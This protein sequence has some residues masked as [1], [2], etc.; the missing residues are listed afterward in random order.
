MKLNFNIKNKPDLMSCNEGEYYSDGGASFEWLIDKLLNQEAF[1]LKKNKNVFI[2]NHNFECVEYK[3]EKKG[4]NVILNVMVKCEAFDFF[5]KAA[6]TYENFN[7]DN[8]ELVDEKIYWFD[9]HK[10]DFP[11][12]HPRWEAIK[13]DLEVVDN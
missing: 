2:E 3:K 8:E 6:D 9:Y 12:Q 7:K 13:V 11:H 1:K 4:K 5:I 10:S